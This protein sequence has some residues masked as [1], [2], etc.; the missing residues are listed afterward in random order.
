[1]NTL[2]LK[3]LLCLQLCTTIL[4]SQRSKEAGIFLGVSNYQGELAPSPIAASETRL[5]IGGIYRLL[6]EKH[7]AVKASATWTRLSGS[8]RNRPDFY[9]GDRDWKMKNS[10][11]ELAV[12]AEWHPFSTNRYDEN[13]LFK[14]QY[15]PFLSL[16]LGAVFSDIDLDVPSDE[17]YKIPEPKAITTFLVVPISAG[18]RFDITE[19]FLLAAEFGSRATF[20]DYLDGIS[21]NG[22][23]KTNDWY[24]FAGVSFIF[25]LEEKVGGKANW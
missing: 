18:I 10:L 8:D 1:M 23:S 16:G 3:L 11:I 17:R 2:T 25:V 5:A 22:N 19:D 15:S 12:H 20:S 13:G 6:Y 14:R 24:F 4:F 7:V 21:E 9:Q